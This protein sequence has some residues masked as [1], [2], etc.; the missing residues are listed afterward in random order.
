MHELTIQVR[1]FDNSTRFLMTRS[2][3]HASVKYIRVDKGTTENL[4]T[5][6]GIIIPAKSEVVISFGIVKSLR[7]W[8]MY[9]NDPSRGFN[10]M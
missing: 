1:S 4:V 9:P 10:I 2:S 3:Y 7:E 8:E 6:S 5:I